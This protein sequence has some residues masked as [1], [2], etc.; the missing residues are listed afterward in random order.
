MLTIFI[1]ALGLE[2][3]PFV[4]LCCQAGDA[5]T[6]LACLDALARSLRRTQ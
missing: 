5:L 2:P 1:Y 4:L 3:A 6:I